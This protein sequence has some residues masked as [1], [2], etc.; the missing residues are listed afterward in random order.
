MTRCNENI[1]FP[2]FQMFSINKNHKTLLYWGQSLVFDVPVYLC[3]VMCLQKHF[4][5]HFS[6]GEDNPFHW[7]NI[8]T[9]R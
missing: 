9:D 4:K 8:R 3:I 6:T 1:A 5:K 2:I 7:A